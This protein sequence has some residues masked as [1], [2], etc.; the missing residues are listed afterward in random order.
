MATNAAGDS[1]PS[2]EA[3]ATPYT[4]PGA[5]TIDSAEAGSS[6]AKVYFTAPSSDGGS[7]IT[8]YIVTSSPGDRKTSGATSPITVGGLTPGTLYTFTVVAKNAAGDSS[9]SGEAQATPYYVGVPYAPTNVVAT[10]GIGE[11]RVSFTAPLLNGGSTITGYTVTS[12]PGNKTANG[13]SLSL[14]VTGLDSGIS[15]TFTVIATNALGNSLASQASAPIINLCGAYVAVGVWKQFMCHN[16]GAT[17]SLD[18]N[19][20]VQEIHGNYYQWGRIAAVADASTPA[21]VVSGWNSTSAANGAWSDASKTGNDPCPTGFR[22]P[23]KVQWN[24]VATSLLNTVSRT[25]TFDSSPTNFSSAIHF[26]PSLSTKT[27]TLP[28]AG[29]RGKDDGTLIIRGSFGGYWSSTETWIINFNN[30]TCYTNSNL[31]PIGFSVRCVSE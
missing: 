24:G 4:V 9:P 21:G 7:T 13:S 27:L 2:G 19:V 10:T 31:R 17:T 26:G 11:A 28:A 12:S 22:V 14:T 30:G 23:T 29:Y 15:Y 16:L 1:S 5:P 25:G 8:E 6:K 18:P 3:Q 20:P